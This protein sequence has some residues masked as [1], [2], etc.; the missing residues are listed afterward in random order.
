MP[1]SSGNNKKLSN[2][3]TGKFIYNLFKPNLCLMRIWVCNALVNLLI[4]LFSELYLLIA[5]F[6]RTGPCTRTA[7]VSI[8]LLYKC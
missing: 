1:E 3:E 5:K 8:L 6:L 7:E 4:C 2:L